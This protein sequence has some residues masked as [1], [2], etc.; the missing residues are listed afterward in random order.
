MKEEIKKIFK[1]KK[2]LILG[3]ARE[4][5]STYKF[6]RKNFPQE[7]LSIADIVK[8]NEL[9]PEAR[10]ILKNDQ[11]VE[12]FLSSFYLDKLDEFNLIVKS[13]GIPYRATQIQEALKKGITFTSQT[14]LFLE[15]I[16]GKVIG[17]TGT[18]GKST[19]ASLISHILKSCNRK[20]VIVGN[21]G[22]PALDYLSEDTPNTIFVYELSS[23]QLFDLDFSP[24]IAI[25][26]NIYNEHTDYYKNFNEYFVAK[27]NI[28]LNQEKSD[29][30][31][32]N[33]DFNILNDLAKKTK[34]KVLSFSIKSK[35]NVNCYIA[36]QEVFLKILGESNVIS[37]KDISLKGFHN[38][39][40]VMAAVLAT[41]ILNVSIDDIKKA[42]TSFKPLEGRLELIREFNGVNFIND[43][44]AT[45]PE[46]T[47][48][49]IDAFPNQK[50]SLIL[51]G[52]ERKLDYSRLT[53]EIVQRNNIVTIVL[54][55]SVANRLSKGLM[56]KSYRGKIINLGK[57]KMEQIVN[58][59]YKNTPKDGIVLLSPA[60]ASFD[61]FKD[62]KDRGEQFK[63][64]VEKIT[65][66]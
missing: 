62:Y 53:S 49:A 35:K 26:L 1:D 9:S 41:D 51:G 8:E 59:A 5:V 57:S 7:V 12:S 61:M 25:F 21:I 63:K 64:A 17:V 33:Y 18:K 58:T 11:K 4:G 27:T 55:G 6:L 28:T 22:K 23:H 60:A 10:F 16:K 40:N 14:K 65:L 13:P 42:I 30:F 20:S 24:H 43:T 34:A 52:Y 37:L 66:E 48:A 54:L 38:I 2:V 36:D 45:I 29:Y 50:I 32:Y 3:F 44:L 31:I 46:A 56:R 19:T 47:L 39:A 15:I